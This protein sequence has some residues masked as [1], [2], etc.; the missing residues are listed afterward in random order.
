M[1]LLEDS[2]ESIDLIDE[3][4]V[5]FLA[6]E[7]VPQ[8]KFRALISGKGSCKDDDAFTIGQGSDARGVDSI[9][10]CLDLVSQYDSQEMVFEKDVLCQACN[11]HGGQGDGGTHFYVEKIIP[12]DLAGAGASCCQ[13]MNPCKDL[14]VTTDRPRDGTSSRDRVCR[15]PTQ[16]GTNEYEFKSPAFGLLKV[17][18]SMIQ[19]EFFVQDRVCK[20]LNNCDGML[21]QGAM[22]DT[23]G[24]SATGVPLATRDNICIPLRQCCGGA[25]DQRERC[26]SV[27]YPEYITNGAWQDRLATNPFTGDQ[28]LHVET[29]NLCAQMNPCDGQ[30]FTEADKTLPMD[31]TSLSNRTCKDT[32][33]CTIGEY[34]KAAPQK[35]N[36]SDL[37]YNIDRDCQPMNTCNRKLFASGSPKNGTIGTPKETEGVSTSDNTCNSDLGPC[38]P[39]QYIEAYPSGPAERYGDWKN[40]EGYTWE[41]DGKTSAELDTL[42]GKGEHYNTPYV[43]KNLN[44]CTNQLYTDLDKAIPTD[45]SAFQ[46]NRTC[47]DPRQCA[48]GMY[49]IQDARKLN[50][51]DPHY[52]YDTDCGWLDVCENKL[53]DVD[54]VNVNGTGYQN[55]TC[56]DVTE[57]VAGEYMVSAPVLTTRTYPASTSVFTNVNS[58]T[59]QVYTKDRE[60]AVALQACAD[61]T[62]YL[63][64]ADKDAKG[65][66]TGPNVCKTKKQCA[67]NEFESTPPTATSDRKC[68]PFKAPADYFKGI[69]SHQESC[70]GA[71]ME[72]HYLETPEMIGKVD[73]M[74]KRDKECIPATV[75][76][77]SG[78]SGDEYISK[79]LTC[80]DTDPT[81]TLTEPAQHNRECKPLRTHSGNADA[82]LDCVNTD[83]V[84]P[85]GGTMKC[86]TQSF[87]DE[88]Q[89]I[90][91]AGVEMYKEDREC[92]RWREC[93]RATQ[94][95]LSKDKPTTTKDRICKNLST[96]TDPATGATVLGCLESQKYDMPDRHPDSGYFDRDFN[97]DNKKE[98]GELC[99]GDDECIY[100]ICF[101]G[102]HAN[103]KSRCNCQ[104]DHFCSNLESECPIQCIENHC[105]GGDNTDGTGMWVS[106]WPGRESSCGNLT[107]HKTKARDAEEGAVFD[108]PWD[109]TVCTK[110]ICPQVCAKH[111]CTDYWNPNVS[112]ANKCG[113][114][115]HYKTQVGA[116]AG[117]YDC[118]GCSEYQSGSTALSGAN[119]ASAYNIGYNTTDFVALS[120]D[121]CKEFAGRRK[122]R[123]AKSE[124]GIFN[125]SGWNG[126]SHCFN[127]S[128]GDRVDGVCPA[129]AC[130]YPATGDTSLSYDVAFA[131]RTVFQTGMRTINNDQLPSGCLFSDYYLRFYYNKATGNV[132]DAKRHRLRIGKVADTTA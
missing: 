15:G 129:S 67:D 91:V 61:T 99:T 33:Q 72:T 119:I 79:P 121:E 71:T 78:G 75:C 98:G 56:R 114:A 117:P 39:G 127:C 43:C 52:T 28:A 38:D 125:K 32:R 120:E 23:R 118:R 85:D 88:P 35:Q 106:Q 94:Y 89:T 7:T 128:A 17:G 20:T 40:K 26:R 131:K 105:G 60:C 58:G 74:Y 70:R 16:C 9:E 49:I 115:N 24:S 93:D 59:Y 4:P 29:N 104:S 80:K 8:I 10:N 116:K 95:V 103:D 130:T 51:S 68:T 101:E 77:K 50:D 30:L 5:Q 92:I 76:A 100:G 86:G 62:K 65:V 25:S 69:N 53:I 42:Y 122:R 123:G 21:I 13:S 113:T 90:T 83:C 6:T 57:C 47:K 2:S 46:R 102:Y 132:D 66:Y 97:C 124:I 111:Q 112:D 82:T 14:L 108:G 31:G 81:C 126:S 107:S 1:V 109:C 63:E 41:G 18:S 44:V 48:S 73:G 64:K 34:Q 11:S 87:V 55:R 12:P 37:H 3:N 19:E 110:N 54:V 36:P 27:Q 96:Q 22:Q 84:N 45:G